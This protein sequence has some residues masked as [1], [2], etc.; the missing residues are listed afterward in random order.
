[1]DLQSIKPNTN[2]KGVL[3]SS[4]RK[5]LPN[6]EGI[7]SNSADLD[8][9]C[10]RPSNISRRDSHVKTANVR[11]CLH[12]SQFLSKSTRST[13]C[14][15]QEPFMPIR[16]GTLKSNDVAGEIA[17]RTLRRALLLLHL[18]RQQEKFGGCLW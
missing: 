14:G 4:G 3:S 15:E 7:T 10:R 9:P 12:F 2:S 18:K 13:P 8:K 6:H 11:K 1:M 5:A 16:S 17:N